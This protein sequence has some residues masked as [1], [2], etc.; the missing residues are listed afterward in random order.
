MS[1]QAAAAASVG[2]SGVNTPVTEVAT[3][4][5]GDGRVE[6]DAGGAPLTF[7]ELEQVTKKSKEKKESKGEP[8]KDLT[9]DADKGKSKK[10]EEEP[11]K[12][13]ESKSKEAEDGK[14]PETEEKPARKTVKAKFA[15]QE[16][17]IDEETMFPVTVSGKEEMWSLKDLRADKSGK[18]AWDKEFTNLHKMRKDLGSKEMKLQETANKIKTIFQEKDP[19]IKM[20]M[21]AQIA[22]VDAVQYR[23]DYLNKN[24]ELL[25][26]YHAMT[27]DERK[28]DASAFEAKIHK[29]RADTLETSSKQKQAFEELTARIGKLRASHQVSE[30]QFAD[31]YDQ[32][33][34]YE[35]EMAAKYSDYKAKEITPEYVVETIQKDRIWDA[36]AEK[37]D[38]LQLNLSTE[39]RDQRLL[40]LTEDGFKLGLSPKDVSEII[41]ELWGSKKTEKRIE[42]KTKQ[43][44]EFMR[45]KSDVPAATKQTKSEAVFF[46]EM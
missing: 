45:G 37:L 26:K 34:A 13:S 36:A 19:D 2:N 27:E 12:K 21:M 25:E 1:T 16:L 20:F 4:N 23:Q 10:A 29:H 28:A 11:A 32:V 38:S 22:G 30:E 33:A 35:R 7:D 24:M 42:E 41:D 5:K 17:E 6:I 15:D 31:R 9:S 14:K 40:K 43:K 46:D 39:A 8:S 44:D 18:T 3:S